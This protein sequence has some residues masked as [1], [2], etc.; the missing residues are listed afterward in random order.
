[1]ESVCGRD[2]ELIADEERL[3]ARENSASTIST[4]DRNALTTL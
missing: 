2:D 3:Q 4:G 1:M